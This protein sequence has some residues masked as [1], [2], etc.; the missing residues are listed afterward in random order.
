MD[1][2]VQEAPMVVP[3]AEAVAV[4]E[5]NFVHHWFHEFWETR[6]E[7]LKNRKRKSTNY[8]HFARKHYQVVFLF[9]KVFG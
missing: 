4:L 7:A 2:W 3:S 9:S 6:Y 8:A 5:M 1:L